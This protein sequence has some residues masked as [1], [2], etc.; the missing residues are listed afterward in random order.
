MEFD[1]LN[2]VVIR[3]PTLPHCGNVTKDQLY[4]ANPDLLQLNIS[5]KKERVAYL[6]Y[7]YRSRYRCTPFGLF[8]GLNI[9]YIGDKTDIVI[10]DAAFKR[11]LRLDTE[12]LCS[13]I[14][15]LIQDDS[16]RRIIKFFPNNTIYQVGSAYRFIEYINTIKGRKH[17]LSSINSNENIRRVLRAC[18]GGLSIKEIA[19][20]LPSEYSAERKDAFVNSLINNKFLISELEPAILGE[21]I[22]NSLFNKLT[23]I[24]AR[25]PDPPFSIIEVLEVLKKVTSLLRECEQSGM[26]NENLEVYESIFVYLKTLNVPINRTRFLQNDLIKIPISA[27]VDKLLLSKV[28][29][30]V[31]A[32]AKLSPPIENINLNRFKEQF[33]ER[34]GDASVPLC[35]VLDNEIGLG[36]PYSQS[37]SNNNPILDKLPKPYNSI[38]RSK[39]E[40][41][42]ILFPFWMSQ[43]VNAHKSGNSIIYINED[44]IKH[45]PSRN[46]QLPDT[47]PIMLTLF[48]SSPNSSFQIKSAIEVLGTGYLGRFCHA[49]KQLSELTKKI[50]Q[51]DE[52]G[53]ADAIFASVCHLPFA[54]VGNILQSPLLREHSISCI[55]QAITSQEIT[56]DDICVKVDGNR[57]KLISKSLGVEII[58]RIDSAYNV[59]HPLNIPLVKFFGD[60]QFQDVAHHLVLDFRDFLFLKFIPRIVYENTAILF[61]ATWYLDE[62]DYEDLVANYEYSPDIFAEFSQ[63]WR[64]PKYLAIVDGDNELVIDTSDG[65][66]ID[67]LVFELKRRK[68]I[69]LVEF[70]VN[71]IAAVRDVKGNPYS[72]EIIFN[73]VS[74]AK[75]E[76]KESRAL[77]VNFEEK[78]IVGT[79]WLFFK[80]YMG[81][82]TAEDF[83]IQDVPSIISQLFEEKLVDSFFFIRYV[84]PKFHIRLRLHLA[85]TQSLGRVISVINRETQQL[86]KDNIISNIII[87]SYNRE[88]DRYGHDTIDIS[89]QIFFIDS[90]TIVELLSTLSNYEDR[91]EA[92][93]YLAFSIVD[94]YLTLFGLTLT[95]KRNYCNSLLK[96]ESFKSY[97][98]SKEIRKALD[99][100]FRSTS[101]AVE[102]AINKVK[103][104]TFSVLQKNNV[105]MAPLID[106]LQIKCAKV[107][108]LDLLANYIHMSLNRLFKSE[109]MFHEYVTY[110][111]LEKYY[112]YTIGVQNR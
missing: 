106:I 28:K 48:D 107:R 66:A 43:I 71:E 54:R 32:L 99:T 80:V 3:T 79:E 30:A 104:A 5:N 40:V 101:A 61:P 98:K 13:L 6:K 24:A 58:P 34:W 31:I 38:D 85:D 12:Y 22:E 52:S 82:K 33:T 96:I 47:F 53:R 41:D 72:N 18:S 102:G 69:H 17:V 55:S 84:D 88:I 73:C 62:S 21:E 35:L 59:N 37:S 56:I 110:T 86:I 92:R 51:L 95:E 45:L 4:F 111:L 89:E 87:D 7:L 39:M 10:D 109:N 36:Y 103:D 75:P 25:I 42:G 70:F 105:L 15:H 97:S 78:Y 14:D 27:T 64:F 9:G 65:E 29:K 90:K 20:A 63:K 8:A 16:T 108:S 1:F 112:R 2:E 81:K 23:E 46:L 77:T 60:L 68:H 76:L 83:I 57:I 49:D 19:D 74:C 44:T 11:H 91:E 26:N 50:V 67:V 93:L 94:N 100:Q